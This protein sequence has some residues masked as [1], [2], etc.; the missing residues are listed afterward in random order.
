[1]LSAPQQ[2]FLPQHTA[3]G[4]QQLETLFFMILLLMALAFQLIGSVSP[5][6]VNHVQTHSRWMPRKN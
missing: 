2:T 5:A 1:M 6:L 3:M 4:Y